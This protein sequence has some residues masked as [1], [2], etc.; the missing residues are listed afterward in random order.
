MGWWVQP[1]LK[2]NDLRCLGGNLGYAQLCLCSRIFSNHIPACFFVLSDGDWMTRE[3][4]LQSK[5]L[6]EDNLIIPEVWRHPVS[7]KEQLVWREGRPRHF[8]NIKTNNTTLTLIPFVAIAPQSSLKLKSPETKKCL[9]SFHTNFTTSWGP[10]SCRGTKNPHSSSKRLVW[11]MWAWPGPLSARLLPPHSQSAATWG[12]RAEHRG[13]TLNIC[14]GL[15]QCI[16]QAAP[17]NRWTTIGLC[18]VAAK[19]AAGSKVKTVG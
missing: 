7:R 15:C 19:S 11:W 8:G 13:L 10:S 2:H 9:M 16:Q 5:W 4:A 14:Q 3:S 1:Q 17:Y 18:R 6:W 12:V